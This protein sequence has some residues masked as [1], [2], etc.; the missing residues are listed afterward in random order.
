MSVYNV[1]IT[2]VPN[3]YHVRLDDHELKTV[4]EDF[5][6]VESVIRGYFNE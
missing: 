1:L 5:D 4:Y 3:G 6:R 2:K